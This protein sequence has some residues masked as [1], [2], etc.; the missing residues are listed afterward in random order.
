MTKKRVAVIF[1]G[2]SSE[3]EVSLVSATAIMQHLDPKRYEVIAVGITKS[4]E[5]RMGPAVLEELKEGGHLTALPALLSTEPAKPGL[6]VSSTPEKKVLQKVDIALPVVH[7]PYGEDG[8]LQGLLEMMNIPY[9]GCGVLASSVAMDKIVFKKMMQALSIPTA[10]FVGFTA[11]E[12]QND[13][14]TILNAIVRQCAFPVFVKPANMGSSIG[15]SKVKS[16]AG[17]ASAI[18]DALH[19]DSR[20]LAEQG[21]TEPREIEIAVLGNDDPKTSVCGEILPSNEFYDYNAKYVDGQSQ[22]VI[23]AKLLP[24]QQKEIERYAK[25]AFKAIDAGG[26]ARVDFLVNGKNGKVFLNEMN[27]I[28]G[29]TSISMYAKLWQKSGVSYTKLLDTLIALGLEKY[30][31]KKSRHLDFLPPAQWYKRS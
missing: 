24:S 19:Y 14:K 20:V 17:L 2:R 30:Q 9:V 3:H 7:G 5:W 11:Y 26:M 8:T 22:E 25:A 16:R 6:V 27:T 1:G 31:Q 15:V 23:P 13:P 21:V 4:G 28:P 10:P 18:S 12:W 29:F